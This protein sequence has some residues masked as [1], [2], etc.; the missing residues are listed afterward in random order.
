MKKRLLLIPSALLFYLIPSFAT[1][2]DKNVDYYKCKYHNTQYKPMS[3]KRV[4]TGL[5]DQAG[6]P[7]Q[8]FFCTSQ[9]IDSCY[10]TGFTFKYSHSARPVML[11]L[12]A[13]LDSDIKVQFWCSEN[14]NADSIYL[15]K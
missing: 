15:V 14:G 11:L 8:V 5:P 1:E 9:N 13:A 6:E 7:N 4:G 10:I 12:L 2:P 3:V